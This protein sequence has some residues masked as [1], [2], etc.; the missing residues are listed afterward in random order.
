MLQDLGINCTLVTL[1][2]PSMFLTPRNVLGAGRTIY[3]DD[4][5]MVIL[6]FSVDHEN[7]MWASVMNVEQGVRVC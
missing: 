4:G 6:S 1:K 3:R 7:G 5:S 2:S